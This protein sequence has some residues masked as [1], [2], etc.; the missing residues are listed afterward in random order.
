VQALGGEI[1]G[2]AYLLLGSEE[3]K[4]IV[5]Q[6]AEAKPDVVL[7]T[8]NGDSN[9]AFFRELRLAG[10]SPQDVPTMSFSVAE[11]E[12][13]ELDLANM[14]GDYACWNYFQSVDTPENRRVV[15]AFREEYGADCVVDDPMEAAYFGVHIWA[16]AVTDAGAEAIGDV[17]QA[18]RDQTFRAPQGIVTID[19]ENHHT[20]KTVRIGQIRPDGQFEVVW[21]SDKPI[22]PVPYPAYRTKAEWQQFLRDLHDGWGG[23]WASPAREHDGG[24]G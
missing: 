6:I 11:R 23:Q 15:A 19:A 22:K 8:I 7:N 5:E 10:I 1:V 24:G 18:I 2:E 16:Q 4:P 9:V 3:A 13:V 17:R 20:W 21:T 14:V 12:L